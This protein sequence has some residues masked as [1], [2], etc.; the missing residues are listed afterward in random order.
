MDNPLERKPSGEDLSAYRHWVMTEV[1]RLMSGDKDL[2][3]LDALHKLGIPR[4]LFLA[5]ISHPV[6]RKWWD[7]SKTRALIHAPGQLPDLE[8]VKER[9]AFG[10]SQAGLGEK[11]A[12]M[13][14]LADPTTEEGAEML[15]KL[16]TLQAKLLP[17]TQKVQKADPTAE[18]KEVMDELRRIRK[19]RE[20]LLN[21]EVTDT[22]SEPT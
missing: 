9:T 20:Q 8:T 14:A 15:L 2:H 16:A 12:I 4:A 18:D 11:L 17:K 19:E 22:D 1:D 3:I 13:T 6:I 7:D 5:N 10:L 21:I